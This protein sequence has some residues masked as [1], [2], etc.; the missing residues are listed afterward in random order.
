MPHRGRAMLL[1]ILCSGALLLAAAPDETGL[2]ATRTSFEIVRATDGPAEF[3]FSAQL[4]PISE[5]VTF[6]GALAMTTDQSGLV[7]HVVGLGGTTFGQ[8]SQPTVFANGETITPCTIAGYC[9]DIYVHLGAAT[10]IVMSDNGGPDVLNRFY[11]VTEGTD[12]EVDFSG[13]GWVLHEA[14]LAFRHVGMHEAEGAG[15][16]LV[17]THGLELFLGAS[18]EGGEFGSIAQAIPPCSQS[19]TNAVARGAG[20]L[21]LTGGVNGAEGH[22][23]QIGFRPLISDHA[24]NATTWR[25]E[26][27]VMGN[28]SMTHTRLFVVDLPPCNQLIPGVSGVA[29]EVDCT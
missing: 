20:T 2:G 13:D 14:P 1:A 24:V 4:R 29:K 8:H 17:T 11:V 23:P 27:P 21:T 18:T 7:R 22:C 25:A 16:L 3:S 28:N 26:G 6:A 10:V 15:T 5:E 19:T 12:P 9:E